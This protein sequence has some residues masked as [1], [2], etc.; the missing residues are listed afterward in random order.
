MQTLQ[1]RRLSRLLTFGC[2]ISAVAFLSE[3]AAA[4]QT[5]FTVNGPAAND[6][7]GQVVDIIGD[8]NGDGFADFMAGGWRADA[9]GPKV[10]AGIV[11]VYSGFN[12]AILYNIFGDLAGDHMGFGSSAAGDVNGDGF[13]DICAAADEADIGAIL[14]AGTIKII[15]GL[16]GSLIWQ[17]SGVVANDL[18][19]WST[20]VI[21]DINNDGKSEV[22]GGALLGN[23]TGIANDT[24]YIKVINGAT[25]LPLYTKFGDSTGDNFGYSCYGAGDVNADGTPD[26]IAGAPTDDNFGSASGLARLFSGATGG[27]IR[28]FNGDNA[29][30]N[31]GRSV[32]GAGDVNLDGFVDIIIGAHLDD[33][34][35]ADSGM[36]RIY[37]G[38]N[39]S[40]HQ[41]LNGDSAG[42]R[43]GTFVRGAGDVDGDGYPDV[44]VGSPGDASGAGSVKVFSGRDWSIIQTLLGDSAGDSMGTSVGA[45]GDINNDG[46]MD[47]V[48]GAIGDDNA[49]A[50]SGSARAYSLIPVGVTHFGIG[51]PGCDG[52][53]LVNANKVPKINTPGF[54]IIGNNAPPSTLNL[55]IVAD[56][57]LPL[58]GDQL[59][60][61]ATLYIDFFTSTFVDGYDFV[62]DATGFAGVPLPIPND[63]GLIGLVAT[64][65]SLSVW[66]VNC[67]LG[68]LNISTS[69]AAEITIQP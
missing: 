28:N 52:K 23:N 16:N 14:N 56:G 36:A 27:T 35:G 62:S 59:G 57:Q 9:P 3:T 29:N 10:D 55:L 60:I 58:G 30:D 2:I 4:Q 11:R 39:F 63:P 67:G 20:G 33:N 37:N 45:G 31:F 51:T 69:I 40:I 34:T 54:G 68:A 43:F 46:F 65:Q 17:F 41:T 18:F 13:M 19:G 22:I 8:A 44:V 21:G 32:C 49:G 53:Q 42:D 64:V 26:F 15:S 61:F 25:G 7:L 38:Q 48:G 66:P 5:L 24:G 47:V 12:G 50:S 1:P 6:V